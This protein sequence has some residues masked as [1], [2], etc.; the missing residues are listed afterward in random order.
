MVHHCQ[1]VGSDQWQL[2][3]QTPGHTQEEVALLVLSLE[4]SSWVEQL[5]A[6]PL[7]Q[8]EEVYQWDY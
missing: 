3:K 2:G 4:Q 8:V 1:L 6:E 7:H 5:A